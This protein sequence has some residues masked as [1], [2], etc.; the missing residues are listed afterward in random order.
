MKAGM[1]WPVGI[2]VCLGLSVAANIGFMLVAN[3]DPAFAVEPDYYRKA[4]AFDSSMAR[5]RASN[6]LGWRVAVTVAP[7]ELGKPTELRL[8]VTDSAGIPIRDATVQ[9]L[10]MHNAR[11]GE[12]LVAQLAADSAQG[13][14]HAALAITRPGLWEI[15]SQVTRGQDQF[16]VSQRVDVVQRASTAV[17]P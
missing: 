10:A 14:Y 12:R 16:A 17:V 13:G 15:R 8:L 11:S 3:D 7:M 6:A 2:V 5:E 4:V 1:A 9:V